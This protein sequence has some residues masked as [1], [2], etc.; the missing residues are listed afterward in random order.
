VIGADG[1]EDEG[2]LGNLVAINRMTIVRPGFELDMHRR[3]A[4]LDQ[5]VEDRR[6]GASE[7]GAIEDHAFHRD[8]HR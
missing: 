2:R 6:L 5:P 3:A 4:D 7:G 1:H 8:R